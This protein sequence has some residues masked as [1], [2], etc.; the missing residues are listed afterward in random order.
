M[1]VICTAGAFLGFSSR[2]C[3][4]AMQEEKLISEKFINHM[5]EYGLMIGTKEE[6][7]FRFRIF[8]DK[9][10]YINQVNVEQDSFT[11]GH[12]MFSTLTKEEGR[13]RLGYKMDKG[14]VIKAPVLLDDTN[15]SQSVDW[16]TAG[17]V[18]AVKNQGQ[19]GSCWAFS[20]TCAVEFAHWR[21]T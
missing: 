12:N 16:R 10:A 8:Q 17:G 9:D 4:L 19:C 2:H 3:K 15:L 14:T 1:N 13:K 5:E 21:A 11:L 6:F 18:N 7:E 20:A